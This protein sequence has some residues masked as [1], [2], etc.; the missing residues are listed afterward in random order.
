MKRFLLLLA[1]AAC[2]NG[3]PGSLK[4]QDDA[5]PRAAAIA[6]REAAEERYRRLNTAVEGLLSAQ[7]DNQRRLTALAEEIRTVR[8]ESTRPDTGKYATREELAKLAES[9][10]EIDRKREADKKLVL[11][12]FEALKKDLRK[13]L[14]APPPSTVPKK[15]SAAEAEKSAETSP[16][17]A[18]EKAGAPAANQEGVWYSVESGNNL[19]AIVTAHNEHFKSEGKKTSVK[20]IQDANPNLKPTGMKVGQKI[21]IPLVPQ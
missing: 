6:E 17:K 11:E 21:F 19:T 12:E 5:A 18:T 2:W 13:M 7:A 16:E 8:A 14:S 15:K 4:A 3:L 1:I 10:R 9:L 20:L